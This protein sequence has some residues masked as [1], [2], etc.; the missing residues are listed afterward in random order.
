MAMKP[1]ATRRLQPKLRMICNGDEEVNTLR[2]ELSGA[3]QVTKKLTKEYERRFRF[4]QVPLQ[5]VAAPEPPPLQAPPE[6][7][8]VSVF[9]ELDE[10]RVPKKSLLKPS[11]QRGKLMTAELPLNEVERVTEDVAY[12]TVGDTL[13]PPT[14]TISSSQV[15]RP[16]PRTV[17]SEYA[18]GGGEGVL[19]GLIDVGGFDWSHLDFLS[20]DGKKTRFW[21]IWDQG[22]EGNPPAGFGYG[23]VL[24]QDAMS[25]ALVW[26]REHHVGATDLLPQSVQAP[27]AHATH[28]ASIAAGNSGVSPKATIAGV[29]LALSEDDRDRRLSFYD[30]TRLAHAV[31][32]LFG[33]GVE[34]GCP[35]VIN[36]S[37]G[38]NGHAHDGSSPICRWIDAAL[39]VP[40]RCVCVAAG[41]AGQ[42][43]PQF[44][45]D[46]GQLMGRIHT[47][48]Q[49]AAS[50][51]ETDIEWRVVGNGDV[52]SSEN[53]LEVWYEAQDLFGVQ[54]KPPS[55][56][57]TQPVRP[58]E[59]IQ[60][61]QLASGTFLSVYNERYHPA[62][63]ANRISV[64]LSPRL[65]GEPV[66]VEAGIWTV[67]LRGVDVRDGRFH[68][69][70]ER[71][72]PRPVGRFGEREFWRLPSYFSRRSNV[73]R[74]SV[75]S[76]ACGHRVVSVAN[77]DEE[78]ERI[79]RSSSQGPTRDGRAKPE[80]AG[81]G[82]NIVAARGFSSARQPWIGM[83]GTSMASPYVAGVAAL[84]L[85]IEPRLSASQIVG[86]IR[87]TAQPLPGSDYN[88]Q[89]DAGFG[90]I[91]PKLC[92][93]DAATAFN[94]KDLAP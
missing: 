77:C 74:S 87:R 86:I 49:I 21:R 59:Y 33:L 80:V 34:L 25:D 27:A 5:A 6:T 35:V 18:A 12:V 75:N 4:D 28:V 54:V 88:W 64:Y 92:L 16:T 3:V 26:G 10:E 66:G 15:T 22:G 67:R 31:D 45:G 41:N 39:T 7:V 38:T 69:W 60:N 8:K 24:T 70:I 82:T 44:P 93:E 1:E 90:R 2:A 68:A 72:D 48:G 47:A 9:V 42:E 32:Y 46:L 23:N 63:G 37:L 51:L 91:R 85:A 89:D 20:D 76:L 53:E 36:V 11:A 30:S 55:G 19:I 52:D 56:G 13:S 43:A 58:G 50:G 17:E 40:G 71:D 73:D 84:M 61:L 29:L 62:N 78:A 57:W 94:E 79:Y 81:A 14:P 65:K 83:T